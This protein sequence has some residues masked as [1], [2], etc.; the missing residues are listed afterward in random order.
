MCLT[1]WDSNKSIVVDKVEPSDYV[2]ILGM[3]GGQLMTILLLKVLISVV[4][5]VFQNVWSSV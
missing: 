1:K 3:G 2:K 5:C 4:S